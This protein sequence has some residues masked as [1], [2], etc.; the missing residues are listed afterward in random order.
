MNNITYLHEK[1]YDITASIQVAFNP[2]KLLA[3]F[4]SGPPEP[5][6]DFSRGFS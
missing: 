3:G 6:A 5:Y 1:S 4:E 2:E